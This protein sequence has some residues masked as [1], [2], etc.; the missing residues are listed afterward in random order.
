MR[1]LR[2]TLTTI[3]FTLIACG[4]GG[5]TNATSPN[6][7]GGGGGGGGTGSTSNA[8]SVGDNFFDP[9]STTVAPGTTVT[10]TWTGNST[11]NVTFANT[12]LSGSGDKSN[13]STFAKK[14]DTVGSFA[15]QCTIHGSSM[16]GTI[17]V[18]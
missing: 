4:G 1:A 18:K 16:S 12:Q 6:P 10:W 14:F 11:H 17:I 13:G 5:G 3:A 8:I 9:A 15:Y 2:W 7:G